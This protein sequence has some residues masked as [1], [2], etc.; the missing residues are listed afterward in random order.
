LNKEVFA[1][2][3]YMDRAVRADEKVM[4][5]FNDEFIPTLYNYLV[6]SKY[7]NLR[8]VQHETILMHICS[9]L[10]YVNHA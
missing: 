6:F 1:W 2:R 4:T 8:V 3:G 5:A 10:L 7:Q 9:F